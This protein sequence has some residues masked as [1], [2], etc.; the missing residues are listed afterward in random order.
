MLSQRRKANR[1]MESL[2]R[3]FELVGVGLFVWGCVEVIKSKDPRWDSSY[4]APLIVV[5]AIIAAIGLV[6]SG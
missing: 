6:V 1:N 4:G 5:G 3:L 2:G